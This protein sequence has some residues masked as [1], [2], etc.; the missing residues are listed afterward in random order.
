[1]RHNNLLPLPIIHENIKANCAMAEDI[2]VVECFY[3]RHA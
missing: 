1:M 2:Q 3:R